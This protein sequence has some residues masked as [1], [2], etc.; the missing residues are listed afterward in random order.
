VHNPL[1]VLHSK[2]EVHAEEKVAFIGISNDELD[3]AK[4]SEL[5]KQTLSVEPARAAQAQRIVRQSRLHR[6]RARH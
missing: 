4:F 6:S 2:L 3:A 5:D 1:K